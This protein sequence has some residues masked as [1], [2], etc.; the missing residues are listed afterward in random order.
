M[1]NFKVVISEPASKKAYQK[2]ADQS[3][4]GLV[5]RK[6]GEK[7][8]GNGLGLAGYELEITGGSDKDGFPMRPDVDGAVRKKVILTSPP[9]YHPPK[10]G[11]RKRK[12]VRG[13]TVSKDISQVN[14]KVVKAGA[15]KL[16]ALL[17][18]KKEKAEEEK[19]REGD[20]EKPAGK[21]E[22]EGKPAEKAEAG[23][24]EAKPEAGKAEGKEDAKSAGK[25]EGEEK[26][27]EPETGKKPEEKKQEKVK[28][29]P[30]AK[31]GV[32]KLE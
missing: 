4:S 9:G 20:K 1:A 7:V 8:S 30:E 12:S 11:K 26:P 14:V 28:K 18:S 3:Q 5:G 2:E 27:A 19:S 22:G 13:N 32:K 15:K 16:E 17:G 23:K 29:D 25:A 10:F 31:M 21:A 6:I 24:A